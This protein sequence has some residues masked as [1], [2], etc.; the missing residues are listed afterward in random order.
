MD[1]EGFVQ[2]MFKAEPEIRYVAIVNDQYE[3]L[4][5]TQREG[6]P[7]LT[8][9]ETSRNF[10]SIVPQI[11]VDAVEKLA[12]YL[13]PVGGITAHYEK[14]LVIFYRVE[15]LIVILSF[16]PEVETPFYDRLTM[17]FK[18]YSAHYLS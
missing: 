10:V 3:I 14:A 1:A 12:P 18:K 4:A 11:I 2:E 5:S 16:E 9:E 17:E 6:V 13:G 7:S 8:P 15:N